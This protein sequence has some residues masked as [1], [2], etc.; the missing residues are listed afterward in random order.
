MKQYL[1]V[2]VVLASFTTACKGN[3]PPKVTLTTCNGGYAL[4]ERTMPSVCGT[5]PGT[6][7][8]TWMGAGLEG[9][10]L[11]VK[12][13]K[14]RNG[15]TLEAGGVSATSEN[16]NALLRVPI[17][18]KLGALTIAQLTGKEP[19]TLAV[20]LTLTIKGKSPG[21]I[22]LPP[23]TLDK[24]LTENAKQ[25]LVKSPLPLAAAPPAKHSVFLAAPHISAQVIGPAT[26][27]ADVDWV[28]V[29]EDRGWDESATCDYADTKGT[30]SK[31]LK[32]ALKTVTIYDRRT[33]A[34]VDVKEVKAEGPCPE[35]AGTTQA[36]VEVE[37]KGKESFA[38]VRAWLNERI[39]TN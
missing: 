25:L 28:A 14:V 33:G 31:K 11:L 35:I 22:T 16:G 26:T 6:G 18:D 13:Q 3:A 5:V 19:V 23:F 9:T 12:I 39:A 21:A 20:N 17:G 1:K 2:C 38:P 32:R 10:D 27:V 24:G 15:S 8:D 29:L 37:F 4:H 36:D 34:T 30:Y 7:E